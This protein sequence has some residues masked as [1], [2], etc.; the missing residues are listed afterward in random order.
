MVDWTKSNKFIHSFLSCNWSSTEMA[1]TN[2]T[3]LVRE[4]ENRFRTCYPQRT[5][6]PAAILAS[7]LPLTWRSV[8]RLC[9]RKEGSPTES[10]NSAIR[11]PIETLFTVVSLL[12][13]E[14]PL[15][16]NLA[17]LS[18]LL[19][20]CVPD[21]RLALLPPAAEDR[22]APWPLLRIYLRKNLVLWTKARNFLL[23][24]VYRIIWNR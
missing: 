17:W 10:S 21:Q 24:T 15:D 12:A 20:A 18:P 8:Y 11:P 23:H 5:S 14:S 1:P 2:C 4:R 16:P 7:S 3:N 9:R 19:R 13:L 6:K 22:R